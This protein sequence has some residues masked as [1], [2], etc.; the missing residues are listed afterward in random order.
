MKV[1]DM[2][3]ATAYTQGPGGKLGDIEHSKDLRPYFEK[4]AQVVAQAE[5][6]HGASI[7]HGDYKID[8]VVSR[9]CGP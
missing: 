7:V 1:S 3:G 5:Q 2:Q 6:I 8:N 9:A 4:G